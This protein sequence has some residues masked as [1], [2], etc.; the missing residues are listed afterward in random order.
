MKYTLLVIY[1]QNIGIPNGGSQT[2]LSAHKKCELGIYAY[3]E[4]QRFF[5]VLGFYV[6]CKEF[7]IA[8]KIPFHQ[9]YLL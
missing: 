1:K 7:F 3:D 6:W 9:K 2:Y 8:K 5:W 4:Y